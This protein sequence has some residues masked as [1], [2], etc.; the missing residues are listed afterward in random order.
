MGLVTL[1]AVGCSSSHSNEARRQARLACS[2]LFGEVGPMLPSMHDVMTHL[3][4]AAA[5]DHGAYAPW[6]A[7]ARELRTDLEAGLR[8]NSKVRAAPLIDEMSQN[9]R[10]VA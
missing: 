1:L 6:L 9:C 3:T 7:N 5:L 8:P 10:T 2:A 4:K